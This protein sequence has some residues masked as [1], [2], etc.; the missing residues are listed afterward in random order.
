MATGTVTGRLLGTIKTEQSTG[1]AGDEHGERAVT[2]YRPERIH[3]ENDGVWHYWLLD[4]APPVIQIEWDGRGWH[5]HSPDWM[6][7][8]VYHLADDTGWVEHLPTE[9]GTLSLDREHRYELRTVRRSEATAW[10]TSWELYE[11][12]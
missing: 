3:L 8:H 9:R 5:V 11:I 6:S 10:Q 1:F 4:T 12:S 7:G 2:N